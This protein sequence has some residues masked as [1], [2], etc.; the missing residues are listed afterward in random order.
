[1]NRQLIPNGDRLEEVSLLDGREQLR[2]GP[3][4][5]RGQGELGDVLDLCN[6][7]KWLWC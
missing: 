2:D 7:P 1:M 5:A 3:G 6:E 4:C